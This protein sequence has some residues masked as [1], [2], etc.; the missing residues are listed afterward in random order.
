[1]KE[2]ITHNDKKLKKNIIDN[3]IFSF[4]IITIAKIMTSC[5][6]LSPK[7]YLDFTNCIAPTAKMIEHFEIGEVYSPFSIYSILQVMFEA[8]D[9]KTRYILGKMLNIDPSLVY[10]DP[11]LVYWNNF[12]SVSKELSKSKEVRFTNC[13]FSSKKISIDKSFVKKCDGIVK[14]FKYSTP[15][16]AIALVNK[17]ISKNTNRLIVNLLG[18]YDI[19]DDDLYIFVNT[20]HFVS[21]WKN[22]FNNKYTRE[23]RF[24]KMDRSTVRIP[25]M[26][27]NFTARYLSNENL[28]YIE[29][30]YQNSKY[31]M[32]VILPDCQSKYRSIYNLE[33]FDYCNQNAVLTKVEL[34]FPKF[35]QESTS[36]FK[37]IISKIA[38]DELFHEFNLSR[39]SKFGS[40][41]IGRIIQKVIV[42]VDEEKTEA[43]AA[44]V[45]VFQEK[46]VQLKKKLIMRVNHTFC[47]GIFYD[48]APL[49]IG[50]YDG[51]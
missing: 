46:G 30:P 33:T 1:M 6:C 25:L 48:D 20:I 42:T 4:K 13:I 11:S 50:L 3:L 43:A 7:K 40:A 2:I 8:S 38:G 18:D 28:Q 41:A 21:K 45:T 10:I 49:F 39:M 24:Y 23:E 27:K 9:G 36:D 19:T 34:Y 47:Y 51:N 37:E 17:Y 26:Y 44:T 12:I 35:K 5:F 14:C 29:L 16:E 32:R 15:E 31:V 22:K